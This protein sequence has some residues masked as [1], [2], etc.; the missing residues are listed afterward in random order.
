MLV[1]A[2]LSTQEESPELEIHHKS[3]KNRWK[4]PHKEE[5]NVK[6]NNYILVNVCPYFKKFAQNN[7]E[8]P[9]KNQTNLI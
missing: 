3:S 5:K 7:V 6:S 2:H 8:K 4:L 1:Q 9:T